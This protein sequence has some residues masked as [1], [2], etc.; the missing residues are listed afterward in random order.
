MMELQKLVNIIK[1]YKIIVVICGMKNHSFFHVKYLSNI[2][3]IEL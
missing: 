3:P 1:Y 2:D